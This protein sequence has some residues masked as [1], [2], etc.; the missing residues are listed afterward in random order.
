MIA[1]VHANT[2]GKPRCW[3]LSGAKRLNLTVSDTKK[4]RL[5][6]DLVRVMVRR[7]H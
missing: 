3:R 4:A 5:N 7:L 6:L 1:L 2:P